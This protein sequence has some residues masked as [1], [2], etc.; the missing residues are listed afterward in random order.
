MV[1]NDARPRPRQG[2]P[3][4]KIVQ[5]YGSIAQVLVVVIVLPRVDLEA[6]RKGEAAILTLKFWQLTFSSPLPTAHLNVRVGRLAVNVVGVVVAI[7]RLRV[8][9][10]LHNLANVGRQMHALAR[11]VV[12]PKGYCGGR[13]K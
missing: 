11:L 4:V 3:I 8:G 6:R 7:G 1:A 12:N 10:V 13:G 5:G 9:H 2:R